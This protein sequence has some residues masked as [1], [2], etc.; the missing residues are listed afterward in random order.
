[1]VIV[2]DGKMMKFYVIDK[3]VDLIIDKVKLE[4]KLEEVGKFVIKEIVV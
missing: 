2:N 4:Y 3:I 1:M